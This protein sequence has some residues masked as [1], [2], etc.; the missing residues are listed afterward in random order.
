MSVSVP[1]LI[2]CIAGVPKN[3]NLFSL[4]DQ[5]SQLIHGCLHFS[6]QASGAVCVREGG[7]EEGREE[8]GREGREGRKG[9]RGG[10][11]ERL[12]F[13]GIRVPQLG[14]WIQDSRLS[15]MLVH[16]M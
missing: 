8:G 10:R 2:P 5:L 13:T 9:E 7:R 15:F 16:L 1:H 4:V 6:L 3:I 11:R 12:A 14:L